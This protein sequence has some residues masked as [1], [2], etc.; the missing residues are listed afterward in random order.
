MD[1]PDL[2]ARPF[3]SSLP[4]D[5][6][7]LVRSVLTRALATS[8]LPIV[9]RIMTHTLSLLESEFVEAVVL[10]MDACRRALNL[11][12][13]VEGPRRTAAAR[14]VKATMVVYTNVLDVA[15]QYTDRLLADL[16]SEAFLTQYFDTK[17][18]EHDASSALANAQDMVSRLGLLT[19]K[20]RSALQFELDE[21]YVT[22][23]EP[24][25]QLLVAELVQTMAYDLTEST[26]AQA[27]SADA[28]ALKLR[29]AWPGILPGYRDQLT[30]TNYA[31]LFARV[32]D[33]VLAP[34]EAAV[35]QCRFTELGALRF[36]E[37]VRALL[38]SCAMQTP[39]GVRDKFVRLQQIAYI[40]TR[41]AEEEHDPG[42]YEAGTA[43]GFSWQLSPAEVETV[44]ALRHG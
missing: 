20:L 33:A 4:D 16:H 1:T 44:H 7:F 31:L 2:T 23:I 39:W 15:A 35:L 12:R 34:W 21:L 13:L 42:A 38:E 37:D 40:L 26:Y 41:E 19:L 29:T 14:E 11:P 6:F 25:V 10:R 43:L 17:A 27:K 9:D 8:S 24:R 28:V 32:L 5:A 18:E 30:E 22:L 36:D 3:T